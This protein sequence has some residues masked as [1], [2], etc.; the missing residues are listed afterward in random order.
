MQCRCWG[1]GNRGV[2]VLGLSGCRARPPPQPD[3][4]HSAVALPCRKGFASICWQQPRTTPAQGSVLQ[5]SPC[6]ASGDLQPCSARTD[7]SRRA[8]RFSPAATYSLTDLIA[9][10]QESTCSLPVLSNRARK[11]RG[12]L[13]FSILHWNMQ[14]VFLKL[15]LPA[16]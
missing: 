9:L 16:K 15:N 11:H 5:R 6:A 7:R 1:A 2:E 13:L 4:Q 3:A 8:L 12:V 14:W 10:K